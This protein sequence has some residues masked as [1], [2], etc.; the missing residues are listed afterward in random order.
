MIKTIVYSP[1]NYT[2]TKAT[3]IKTTLFFTAIQSLFTEIVC[4][5]LYY[6]PNC[7]KC[8]KRTQKLQIIE[9]VAL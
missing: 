6:L 7:N 2:H 8:K 9:R 4:F 5:H 3:C 1:K